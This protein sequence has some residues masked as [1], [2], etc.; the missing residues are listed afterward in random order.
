MNL[1]HTLLAGLAVL[2]V[3]GQALACAT[4]GCSAKKPQRAGS[5][6]KSCKTCPVTSK[7][8]AVTEHGS[9]IHTETLATLLRAKVPLVVTTAASSSLNALPT[10]LAKTSASL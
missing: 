7:T 1:R 10:N 9:D 5:G 3:S 2:F 8:P 6:G 4:C